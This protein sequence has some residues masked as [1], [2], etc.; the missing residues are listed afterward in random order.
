MTR[1]TSAMQPQNTSQKILAINPGNTSTKAALFKDRELKKMEV[2]RHSKEEIENFT[3][4]I[5]QLEYRRQAIDDF[6][7]R[8]KIDPGTIDYF[9]GRGGYLKPLKSGLY[10][11]NEKM[12]EDL[13]SSRYG[14]H[15]SNL[16]AMIAC[17]FSSRMGKRAFI[18]DPVCVDELESI[19]R[20]SG[21]P[22]IERKSVFHTLNQKRVA[23]NAA[24]EM[25]LEY[26][27]IN[28]IVAHLGSGISV[29]LHKKG[30]I[31][32]VTNAIDGEGPFS[33][34]RS[35][36]VP[37]GAFL[38]YVF[39]NKLDWNESASMLYGRGGMYA[40]LGTNDFEK[41]IEKYE[42][43]KDEKVKT[44]VEAMAY[45]ITKN[46][47]AMAAPAGGAIDAIVITGGLAYSKTFTDL[48]VPNIRFI[49]DRVFIYPGEDELQAIADG[50]VQGLKNEI[51][52]LDY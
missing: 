39:D 32:D 9:I 12:L 18:L 17:S 25:G 40:Y 6:L 29:G 20:I 46:I 13:K 16:G 5:D 4:F 23:R 37:T 7:S 45:Q 3:N 2:V 28:L 49:T 10:E 33:P 1:H 50:V 22:A 19:A 31:T 26:K 38:K 41:V 21:H 27:D 51:E 11:V 42:A 15:A 35:G 8:N 36:A 30:L 43:K 47:A 48:I 24:R 44:I 52:I 14:E 34:E